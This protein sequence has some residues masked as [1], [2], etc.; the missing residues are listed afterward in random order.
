MSIS[1][2]TVQPDVQWLDKFLRRSHRRQYPSKA[3]IIYQGSP[4]E[5]LFYIV[6]GSVSVSIKGDNGREIVLAYLSDGDFF[7]EMGLFDKTERSAEVVARESC[8]LAE[9]N[10][11]Q[12]RHLSASQPDLL[13]ALTTQMAARLRKT[14]TKVWD[15]AFLDV[16]GRV[17]SALL[18]L[19]KMPDAKTHPNGMQIKITRIEL[20]RIAGC[21]REMVGRVLKELKVRNLIHAHGKTIVIHRVL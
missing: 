21:S 1:S 14:S 12:F 18:D 17:E 13:Y 4:A 8:E 6:R 7:G 20:A 5:T 16:A 19:A 10:Y 2:H 15:L 3:T 11:D 9:V